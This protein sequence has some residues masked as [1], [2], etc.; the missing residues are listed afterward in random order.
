MIELPQYVL[1]YN[2]TTRRP[3]SVS[4]QLL[5]ADIS[6]A[7][8]GPIESDPL[9]PRGFA[10]ETSHVYDGS[11]FDHGNMCPAHDRSATPKDI[12]ATFYMTSSVPQ[13]PACNQHQE[14]RPA[15]HIRLAPEA[16]CD[17]CA[18]RKPVLCAGFGWQWPRT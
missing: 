8:R 13:S 18:A 1:S 16:G 4:W 11:G 6:H 3:N 12:A 14:G 7:A 2:A 17:A 5:K 10:K 15:A 9:L